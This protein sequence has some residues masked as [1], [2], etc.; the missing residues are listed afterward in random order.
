ML[1][2]GVAALTEVLHAIRAHLL[3][4]IGA[5]MI[6]RSSSAGATHERNEPDESDDG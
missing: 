2:D 6:E 5:C 3:R 4:E 1:T